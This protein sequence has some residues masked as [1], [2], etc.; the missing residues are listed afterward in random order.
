MCMFWG[1]TEE[2]EY[3]GLLP[4]GEKHFCV[5]VFSFL[6]GKANSP[7]QNE[8]M[9]IILIK[10]KGISYYCHYFRVSS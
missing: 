4:E 9:I 10:I 8:I 5:P 7:K 3:T 1:S 2:K 6:L